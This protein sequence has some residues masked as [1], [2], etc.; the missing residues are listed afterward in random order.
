MSES[1]KPTTRPERSHPAREFRN[2]R[3]IFLTQGMGGE[4]D[5]REKKERIPLHLDPTIARMIERGKPPN[6]ERKKEKK[7]LGKTPLG[8]R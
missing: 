4:E 5:I 2:P 1:P 8:L 7:L 6:P 3:E